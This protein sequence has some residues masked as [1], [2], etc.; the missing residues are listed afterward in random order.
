MCVLIVSI[1]PHIHCCS[2]FLFLRFDLCEMH[3][4]FVLRA[5][6]SHSCIGCLVERD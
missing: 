5:F 4:V 1:L 6:V 3:A 2:M